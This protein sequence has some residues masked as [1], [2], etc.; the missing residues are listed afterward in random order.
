MK[1]LIPLAWTAFGAALCAIAFYAL[2]PTRTAPDADDKPSAPAV[3]ASGSDTLKLDARALARTGVRVAALSASQASEQRTGFARALDVGALAAIDAEAK[4]ADA[5]AAASRAEAARLATLAS[6][7][8]SAS[9]RS[10]EAARAQA[11]SDNARAQLA[12]RRVGLEFGPGLGRLGRGGVS[13]LV[14][15]VAAGRAALVRIDI[16]GV[17]LQPGNAVRIGEGDNTS[18]VR[19]LGPAASA[20]I[21]LQSAGVLAV[22]RGSAAQGLLAGRVLPA[23][24]DSG[25]AQT[26]IIVPRDAIIRYQGAL[27]I[28]VQKPDQA[29][30]RVEL[31]DARAIADGWFVPSGLA[32]GT[33]VA[34]TGAGSLMAIE[35]GSETSDE[36]E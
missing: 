21:K 4:A 29:F 16:A 13:A 23:S 15:D 1:R 9:Q 33:R 2:S 8:Q 19:V 26:G 7:D 10:V 25:A 11:Q 30:D 18:S 36:E 27:W 31:I 12:A 28:Y 17:T 34:I 14:G 6:Q 5:T 22:V 32:P 3:V 35:R 24:T 20:D